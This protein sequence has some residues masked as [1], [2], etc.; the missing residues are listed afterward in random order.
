[1][2]RAFLLENTADDLRTHYPNIFRVVV[3]DG[4]GAAVFSW[5]EIWDGMCTAV[6]TRLNVF[7]DMFFQCATVQESIVDYFL[8]HRDTEHPRFRYLIAYLDMIPHNEYLYDTIEMS[9]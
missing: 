8:L 3:N 7:S 6:S 9:F 4:L 2:L 1:M 5:S